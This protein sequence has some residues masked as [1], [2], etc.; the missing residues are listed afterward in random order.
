MTDAFKE[1]RAL[2][3]QYN[4]AETTEQRKFITKLIRMKEAEISQIIRT[5]FQLTAEA[6][7]QDFLEDC[8]ETGEL[9]EFDRE[10]L[11][12]FLD[13]YGGKYGPQI[14]QWAYEQGDDL[15]AQ[16]DRHLVPKTW[17]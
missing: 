14:R 16:L 9:A 10:S 4:E 5:A 8:I 6:V 1:I 15:D 11:I 12:E 7:G 3:L 2:H 13:I 17:S